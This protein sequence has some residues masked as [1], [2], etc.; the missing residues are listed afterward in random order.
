ML[1]MMQ[2]KKVPDI[3]EYVIIITVYIILVGPV[4]YFILGWLKKL[5]YV[6]PCVLVLVT[7]FSVCIYD[8]NA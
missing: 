8:T 6:L 4:L 3:R 1:S 5:K 2:G 7:I